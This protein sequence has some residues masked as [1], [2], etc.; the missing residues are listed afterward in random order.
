MPVPARSPSRRAAAPA[1][2]CGVDLVEV[3]L[4]REALAAHG[5]RYL[6]RVYTP[7]ERADADAAEEP[8][9]TQRLAARFAAKEA[10]IKLLG[11]VRE[12]L[13]WH[14]IEVVRDAEGACALR[15]RGAAARRARALRLGPIA[16]SLSHEPHHAIAFVTACPQAAPRP[17]RPPIPVLP[18]HGA[19]P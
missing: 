19:L 17:G 16:L 14:D 6:A 2:R 10:V 5:A 8:L 13:G 15:L 9:R 12:G 3:G 1:L 4:V 7:A 18:R 11:L